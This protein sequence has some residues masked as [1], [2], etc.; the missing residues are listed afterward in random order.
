M[1]ASAT[2]GTL[3]VDVSRIGVSLAQFVYLGGAS[4]LAEGVAHENRAGYLLAEQ[5]AGMWQD[6]GHA[7]AHVAATDDGRVPDLDT[8]DVGDRI[9]PPS[10][11]D[12]DLQ[13][14]VGGTGPHTG[15]RVLPDSGG[16][17]QQ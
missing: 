7:G 14:Q 9:E 5:V 2:R 15:R 16:G 13:P 3:K 1:S 10:R 12:T 11:Q 17:H 8:S 6:G 4:Q